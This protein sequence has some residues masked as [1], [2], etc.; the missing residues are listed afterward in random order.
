MVKNKEMSRIESHD[1]GPK[2]HTLIKFLRSSH[3]PFSPANLSTSPHL[4]IQTVQAVLTYL[5]REACKGPIA[6]HVPGE[7][8]GFQK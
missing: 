3:T 4:L 8:G 2:L 6:Y 5:E 7:V 1:L